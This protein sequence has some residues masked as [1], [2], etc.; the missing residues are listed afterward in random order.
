MHIIIARQRVIEARLPAND[1]ID[2]QP[3]SGIRI[4]YARL[5]ND[6]FRKS[7]FAETQDLIEYLLGKGLGIAA[8]AH[9]VDQSALERLQSPLALPGRHRAAQPVRLAGRETGRDDR[10]LHDLLLKDRHPQ[11]AL[12]H[13]LDR[14]ARITHRLLPASAAQV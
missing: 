4:H 1:F 3:S 11:R 5:A 10:E 6:T 8:L 9:A 12:E 14:L 7:I 2:G 13:R